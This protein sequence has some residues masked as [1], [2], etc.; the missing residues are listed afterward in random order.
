LAKKR[1]G[2]QVSMWH[3]MSG[4]LPMEDILLMALL[5]RMMEM[6]LANMDFGMDG[7]KIDAS[8]TLEWQKCLGGSDWMNFVSPTNINGNYIV[9]GNTASNDGDVSGNHGSLDFG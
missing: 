8:G 2:E 6:L 7:I 1:W 4:R 9:A 5:H 3:P